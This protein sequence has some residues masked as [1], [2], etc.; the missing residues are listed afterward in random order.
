MSDFS[1][2]QQSR[3]ERLEQLAQER[4]TG[5][6]TLDETMRYAVLGGG[7]RLRP[8]LVW[9][10]AQL[11]DGAGESCDAP[12]L[13]VELLHSY[14]LVHD[15]LP[16]MDDDAMRRGQPAAH[17][18][19]GEANALLAGDSLQA[20]AFAE[21]ASWPAPAKLRLQ[22]L[23]LL[24]D[25]TLDM[26]QGQALDLAAE[27]RRPGA[28]QLAKIQRLKTASLIRASVQ[29]GALAAGVRPEHGSWRALGEFGQCLGLAFQVRDDLMDEDA[30]DTA[31]PTSP[32]VLGT[33]GAEQRLEQLAACA[34]EALQGMAG[35]ER[36]RQTADWALGDL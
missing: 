30:N 8:T 15:D 22:A 25:A 12:A 34:L 13:A 26:A 4:I 35:A 27:H 1:T 29:L 7:K 5:S 11:M 2:W 28:E 16:A 23:G 32:A 10:A 14:S 20:L 9:A 17:I 31:A 6:G 3:R 19:F 21:L 36:L 33:A 24:L 18:A